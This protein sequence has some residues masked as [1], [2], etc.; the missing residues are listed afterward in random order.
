MDQLG[1]S[2][3]LSFTTFSLRRRVPRVLLNWLRPGLHTVHLTR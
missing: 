3:R 2:F 1:N